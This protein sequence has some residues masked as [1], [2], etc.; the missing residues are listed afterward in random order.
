MLILRIEEK[1][2]KVEIFL[3]GTAFKNRFCEIGCHLGDGIDVDEFGVGFAEIEFL[4]E[5]FHGVF[6]VHDVTLLGETDTFG[7][8]M[9]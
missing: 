7:E 5:V 6:G 1:R 4:E 9:L 2:V 8:F 3:R